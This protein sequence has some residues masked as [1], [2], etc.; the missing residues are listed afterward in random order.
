M[1][2]SHIR[3]TS[4]SEFTYFGVVKT[5]AP[6]SECD[7]AFLPLGKIFKI[8][9]SLPAKFDKEPI[10]AKDIFGNFIY[11]DKF[12]SWRGYY[13]EPCL[14]PTEKIT[15]G[16]TCSTFKLFC[17][18][19][20]AGKEFRGY[21]GGLFTFNEDS[22]LWVSRYGEDDTGL[23]TAI[24]ISDSTERGKYPRICFV[25]ENTEKEN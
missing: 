23:I 22:P 15:K 8:I 18:K 24:N 19:V 3:T 11:L 10:R 21:K 14:E 4:F 17:R 1:L 9:S 25:V 7:Y 2:I 6:I 13:C 12:M 5:N 20:F 16:M